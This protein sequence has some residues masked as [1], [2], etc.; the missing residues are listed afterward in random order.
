MRDLRNRDVDNDVSTRMIV[1]HSVQLLPHEPYRNA[2]SK[3][4]INLLPR[5]ESVTSIEV[6]GGMTCELDLARFWSSQGPTKLDLHVRFR[7]VISI[8]NILCLN[9]GGGGGKVLVRSSITDEVISPEASLTHWKTVL[10]PKFPG[11][12]K[13]CD[14]RDMLFTYNKRIHQLLLTYEFEMKD[15]GKVTLRAPFFQG[16]L[17]ESPFESQMMLIFDEDK[18]YIGVADSWPSECDIPKGKITI[19]MQIRHDDTTKLESF[20]NSPIWIERKLKKE[21]RLDVF[22][23]HDAMV[24]KGAKWI[25]TTLR[26]GSSA[27]VF[28]SEPSSVDVPSDCSIGDILFGTFRMVDVTTCPPSSGKKPGSNSITYVVGPKVSENKNDSKSLVESDTRTNDEKL[29]ELIRDAKFEH[30]KAILDDKEVDRTL[31]M[32]MYEEF[33]HD[34][35]NHLSFHLLILRNLDV[36]EKRTSHFDDIIRISNSVISCIDSDK[37]AS[38]FGQNID[39]EDATLCSQKKNYERMK[40]QLIEALTRKARAYADRKDPTFDEEF[41]TAIKNLQRW[42]DLKSDK[43][44]LYLTIEKEKRQSRFASTM[45]LISPLIVSRGKETLDGIYPLTKDDLVRERINLL[46]DLG[47]SSLANREMKWRLIGSSKS[48]AS[49]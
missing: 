9:A 1:L 30:F 17:Y 21:I 14:D 7:G 36:K 18:R 3:K 27:A 12:V 35:P 6:F 48:Y 24:T 22:A 28:F 45:Q 10:S 5:E 13:P 39:G 33:I 8:P 20:L 38:F 46:T 44:F 23:S 32:Q 19:R 11:L 31:I 29:K 2:E 41:R 26:E 37:L 4:Y 15:A 47:Y 49:F 25:K 34:Y 40:E 16:Y 43:K 42:V